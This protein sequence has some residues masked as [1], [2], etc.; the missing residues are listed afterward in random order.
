[1]TVSTGSRARRRATRRPS[2]GVLAL[3]VA[4]AATS[5][6]VPPLILLWAQDPAAPAGPGTPGAAATST[7]A[8]TSGRAP[9]SASATT[10]AA[11]TSGSA[12]ATSR[13]ARPSP[14]F[15]PLRI[16][17]ADPA[18]RRSGVAVTDCPI[19]ASGR[20]VQYLGQGHWLIVTVRVPAAGWRTLTIVYETAGTRTLQVAVNGDPP[21]SLSLAGAGSWTSPA[22]V[23]VPV[24]LVAGE[25]DVKFYNDAE[26]A[27]DL[28]QILVT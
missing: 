15:R 3:S 23:S 27:P 5:I 25:N 14:A 11:T 2:W 1:V 17:A 20:R 26:A 12:V 18:N 28:D 13:T 10:S 19:C 22:R 21:R 16:D 6:A 4:V 8:S 7:A 24:Q 9:A